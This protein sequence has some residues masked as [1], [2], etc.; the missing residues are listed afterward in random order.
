MLS[1]GQGNGGTGPRHN[2]GTAAAEES[3]TELIARPPVRLLLP[4]RIFTKREAI[5]TC[6]HRRGQ[7]EI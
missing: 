2:D 4:L 7:N 1:T 3:M 5:A 6:L